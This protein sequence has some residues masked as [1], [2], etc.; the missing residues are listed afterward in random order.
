MCSADYKKVVFT[1]MDLLGRFFEKD[2]RECHVPSPY[3]SVRFY[4]L[5]HL[6]RVDPLRDNWAI[7]MVILELLVGSN[8]FKFK[9]NYNWV[10]GIYDAV[11]PILN[12]NFQ[13]VLE[14][15]CFHTIANPLGYFISTTLHNQED[16][17]CCQRRIIQVALY[18]D[19]NLGKI[20]DIYLKRQK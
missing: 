17:I 7:G 1:N 19:F 13:N 14:F 20:Y 4:G 15:L 12:K 8:F 2:D 5:R 9:V 3:N 6:P 18:D 10:K 11:K 16:F